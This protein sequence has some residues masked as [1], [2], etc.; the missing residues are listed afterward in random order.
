MTVMEILCRERA[1]RHESARAP[2]AR[3][4][5]KAHLTDGEAGSVGEA[6]DRGAISRGK[7]HVTVIRSGTRTG[8]PPCLAPTEPANN[9]QVSSVA[10]EP[11]RTRRCRAHTTTTSP[12]SISR[13]KSTKNHA[14]TRK[15]RLSCCS[16]RLRGRKAK[17]ALALF[18]LAW[19]A[20]GAWPTAQ[21]APQRV[22]HQP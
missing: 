17:G 7:L 13:A 4:E 20:R 2:G 15:R 10:G 8:L 9:S 18:K 16:Y 12:P 5:E 19:G 3:A 1:M 11:V 21:G 14:A 6:G 22:L